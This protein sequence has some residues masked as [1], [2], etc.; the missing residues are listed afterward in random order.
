MRSYPI[1]SVFFLAL[2]CVLSNVFA[3]EKE[4]YKV[5]KRMV[6]QDGLSQSRILCILEDERGFMWFGSADGLNRYDGYTTKIFRNRLG[7]T[8]SLPNNVINAMAEDSSGNIWIGT[9][10]GVAIFDPYTENFISLKETDSTRIAMG[11]N[12]IVSLVIDKNQDVWCGT[13]GYGVFRVKKN[14]LTRDYH[15]YDKSDPVFLNH[16][17]TLY[18][19][20]QNRLW[21]GAY[22]DDYILAYDIDRDSLVASSIKTP[23]QKKYK[24]Y[25]ALSFYEDTNHRIW[26]SIMDYYE[27][28]GGLFYCEPNQNTFEN[29]RHLMD[30]DFSS[31]Y[32]YDLN[33][34]VMITGNPQTGQLIGASLLGGIFTFNFGQT[35]VVSYSKSPGHDAPIRC[36][37]H[38]SNGILW[39]GTNGYGVEISFPYTTDFMLINYNTRPEFTI[40][41]VRNFAMDDQ[42]YWVCGY[43]GLARISRDFQHIEVIYDAAVYCLANNPKDAQILWTGSEGGGV[44]IYNTADHSFSHP[45]ADIRDKPVEIDSYVFKIFPLND[46]LIL[47][48]TNSGLLG[49]NPEKK[50]A[51]PYPYRA[52]SGVL[53]N[54]TVRSITSDNH[55]NVLV[56]YING[57]IGQ[58]D[59]NQNLVVKF[60][61]IPNLQALN[62]YN[63]INCIYQDVQDVYWIATTNGL[64]RFDT[65]S[66]KLRLFTE[67]DGLPNSH[68]YGILPDDLGNLWMST[69]KGLSCYYPDENVFRNY[70]VS[71]GLQ[72]NEFNTGAYFQDDSGH[73][74]FGGINGFNYFSPAKI[75]QNSIEPKLEI[76]GIKIENQYLKPDKE[77]LEKHEITLLPNQD[78]FTLE[79]AGLSYFNSNKNQYKYRIKE[80]NSDWVNLGTQH[81]LTFNNM[82]HGTYTLEILAANNHGYWLDKPFEFTINVLPTFY[83]SAAFIWLIIF[84]VTLIV[85]GGIRLRLTQLTRQKRKL[86]QYADKQTANLRTAN[87]SLKEEI[88]KHQTTARELNASNETKDKFLSIIGHDLIGPLGVIQGFS[89]L[90]ADEDGIYSE[91]DKRS[92]IKMINLT[93][94]ELNSLLVNL[95][96]WSKLKGDSFPVHPRMLELKRVVGEC[97]ALLRANLNEKEIQ[98]LVEIDGD[99]LVYADNNLLSTI[100]RNLVSNAIKF[101]PKQGKIIIRSHTLS[102]VEQIAIIDTGV[103]IS[104]ENQAKIFNSKINFTT[105]GTN[106]ES[107]TGLGLGLVHEFVILSGGE[108]KVESKQDHG[109]TFIFTLP[110]Q[111]IK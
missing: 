25:L 3:V 80:I 91:K 7:D 53:S 82:A 71:D 99:P 27:L 109:T 70:D 2:L 49:Y 47:F 16:I 13:D 43:N 65:K 106:N 92:F 67:Q 37:Y 68:I 88:V 72:S 4:N 10:N 42:N 5:D 87:L 8:T 84:L 93:S 30:Q 22:L 76:T 64:I 52:S 98:L 46:T 41:S 40:E 45:I 9:N 17:N 35:P 50:W 6:L 74:F 31:F 15:F 28:K 38:S 89:D 78:V 79:F 90:L 44:Q 73:L 24:D 55:G 54:T 14:S 94:K 107:G 57:E 39:I 83:E 62:Q 63:P 48:G 19:D 95:L 102:E 85:A 81:Q 21:L 26:V 1:R 96:Q 58:V 23:R 11:A 18:V 33:S 29:Y 20:S 108:I 75:K 97:V 59:I 110:T 100:L 56:G 32:Y 101:T 104:E 36:I 34:I 111:P 12:L 86:Q 66:S 103:G 60:D 61:R 77:D 105:K 51:T 69:N